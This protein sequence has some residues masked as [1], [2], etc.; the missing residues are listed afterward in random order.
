MLQKFLL[1]KSTNGKFRFAE[2][3]TDEEWHDDVKGYTIQRSYGQ[4]QGK[5][6]LSPL[7]VV[8]RTKQKRNWQEQYT[9]QFNSEVK[10]FLD[11]GYKE[12][13]KHP[14]EYTEEELHELYGSVTTNQY[15]IIKPMLAKQSEKVTN[16]KIFDKVWLGSRK[17]NG[18]RC[19][20]YWDG[21]N[22]QTASRGGEHYNAATSHL[23]EHPALRE[24]FQCNPT[25]ILDGELYKHGKSLQQISGAARMEKN[26]YDC[27]WLE[28]WVY[29]CIH[30]D[31]L[32]KKAADRLAWLESLA[33]TY[34][35]GFN[36]Y[37]R[38]EEGELQLQF[39]PQV[40][41]SGWDNM[42]KLHDEYV[43]EGFEGLVIRDPSK[44]YKPNG[45]TND[46]IKIKQYIDE[47]F[48]VVGYELGLRGS[49]D[50]CFICEM[51]DGRTFKAMPLGDRS[52]KAEYIDNFEEK[53]NGHLGDCKYFEL[54]D[55]GK[56]C[57]PKFLAF[58]FDLE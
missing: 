54:S 55:E 23:R 18:T 58:R 32:D 2:V 15:G 26:A 35:I 8:D 17:I 9:L 33:N 50:M 46:M 37:K 10:K 31:E 49:E 3:F 53:Y 29:D 28:Y 5:T 43:S 52:V 13:E 51:E 48:K 42:K 12:V 38:W 56:P 20:M 34:N 22:I 25:L 39:V 40:E 4:V 1:G 45:R 6:T 27:D 7:I 19:L 24:I 11:K 57:Q 16:T 36:P 30:L 44:P 41:V 47:T 14:N 21:E